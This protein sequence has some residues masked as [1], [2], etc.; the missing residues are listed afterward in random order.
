MLPG[1]PLLGIAGWASLVAAGVLLALALRAET[2]VE[3]DGR[4]WELTASFAALLAGLVALRAGAVAVGFAAAF[5]VFGGLSA[6][7]AAEQ[8]IPAPDSALLQLVHYGLAGAVRPAPIGEGAAS[9]V[10]ALRITAAAGFL[11]SFAAVGV[12]SWQRRLGLREPG[13]AGREAGSQV[14]ALT[15]QRVGQALV[16][17]GLCGFGLALVRF[18]ASGQEAPTLFA[19]LKSFWTGGSYLLTLAAVSMPGIGLWLSA[20]LARADQRS[21]RTCGAVAVLLVLASVPTGQRGF[22]IQVALVVTA[23]LTARTMMSSRTLALLVVIG[24]AGL[25]VTQAA[26]NAAREE[27]TVRVG[28]MVQRLAPDRIGDLFGSQIASF[29]WTWDVARYR[30]QL[31]LPGPVRSLVSKPIPRALDPD[32]TQ[33]FGTD[34]TAEVYP[35]AAAQDVGFATPLV[36]EMDYAYGWPGVAAAFL[37]LG[38]FTAFLWARSQRSDLILRPVLATAI[39]WC[40]FLYLRGDLANATVIASSWIVPLIVV[41]VLLHRWPDRLRTLLRVG[42]APES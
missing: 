17:L 2:G 28:S 39:G 24:A 34:F 3:L 21:V 19:R 29:R 20:A 7:A 6:V 18:A 11:A 37:V 31:D 16:L 27:G 40:A 32:K 9:F 14:D 1:R 22:G 35:A 36:A 38:A 13:V 30:P 41:E 42:P 8:A 10:Y 5:L 4:G 33:G 23:V 15:I 26:R 12:T 25:G